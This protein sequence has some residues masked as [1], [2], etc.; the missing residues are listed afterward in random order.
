[1]LVKDLWVIKASGIS[2]YHYRNISE[3]DFQ[4]DDALFAGFIS[5][6]AAFA[7]SLNEKQIDFLKMKEDE[8]YFVTLDSIIVVAI[9][10]SIKGTESHVIE[11]LLSY[12]GEKF[13]E[14]FGYQIDQIFFDFDTITAEFD[15]EIKFITNSEIYEELKREMINKLLSDVISSKNDPDVLHWKVASLFQD[16]TSEEINQVLKMFDNLTNV[17]P[18]ITNNVVLESKIKDAFQ[19]ATFQLISTLFRH[20]KNNQLYVLCPDNLFQNIFNNFLP[21]GTTC[22]KFNTI[23]TLATAIIAV[24]KWIKSINYQ[25]LIIKPELSEKEADILTSVSEKCSVLVWVE[26][27]ETTI[28]RKLKEKP[29][30]TLYYNYCDLEENCPNIFTILNHFSIKANLPLQQT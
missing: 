16:S 27:L 26:N 23:E 6:L 22:S 1:M 25:L 5:A 30:I 28:Q 29:N 20:E 12:V 2:M 4:L 19:Q 13:I 10:A 21:L 7:E 11:Q 3:S 24:D 9:I 15:K 18:S 8:I 17:L 14:L